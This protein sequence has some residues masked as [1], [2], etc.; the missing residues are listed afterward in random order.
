MVDADGVSPRRV[1][2]GPSNHYQPAW[3]PDGRRLAYVTDADLVVADLDGGT[4]RT[5]VPLKP[6]TAV[7]S[8]SWPAWSPDGNQI[9]FAQADSFDPSQGT[10]FGEQLFV[11]H[12]DG[13]G[14]WQLTNDPIDVNDHSPAFSPD[15]KTIAYAQWINNNPA[16]AGSIWLMN[17]DGTDAHPL[18]SV[19]GYPSGLSWSPDGHAVAFACN[20]A[21]FVTPQTSGIYVLH[22]DTGQISQVTGSGDIYVSSLFLERPIWSRDG[23]TIRYTAQVGS[24]VNASG[25]YAI[26]PDGT[27]GHRVLSQPWTFWQADWHG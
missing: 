5:I 6:T 20:S 13:T 3:S 26:R 22:I 25:V 2:R 27:D 15:G 7:A 19:S 23:Q 4:Q 14:L 21:P 17:S 11:V 18:A 16:N 1:T 24:P 9:V 12:P 8:V 10:Q